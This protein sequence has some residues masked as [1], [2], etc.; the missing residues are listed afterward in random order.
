[1]GSISAAAF[2]ELERAGE[3]LELI[4][5][6]SPAEYRQVH[7]AFASNVPLDQLDPVRVMQERGGENARPLY[8]V[9]HSGTR[10]RQAVELFRRAGFSTVIDVEGGTVACVAAGLPAVHGKKTISLDRQMR[11]VAGAL[12]FS[13]T[14]LGLW[15]RGFL[16]VPAF[17]GAG[18]MFAGITDIC[19]M[20]TV[21]ARMPWNRGDST[22]A[23]SST[24][25]TCSAK[26]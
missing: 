26:P 5:V 17:V 24:P 16:V 18:L 1:M 15:H 20:L 6:R 7:V 12:A 4:D 13:G 11:I 8:V 10:S 14:L 21:L 9:C 22:A 25:P 19:P 23:L 3:S 2:A